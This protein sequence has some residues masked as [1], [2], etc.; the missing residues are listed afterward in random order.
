MINFLD[1]SSLVMDFDPNEDFE[2]GA[3]L[4]SDESER[5]GSP[6]N[7][8]TFDALNDETFGGSVGPVPKDFSDFAAN[9]TLLFFIFL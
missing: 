3:A 4:P 7:G 1:D 6:D 8:E 5:A 2:F 9:V